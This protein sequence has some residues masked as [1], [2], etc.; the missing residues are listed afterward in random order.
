MEAHSA[1]HQH[2]SLDYDS[3]SPPQDHQGEVG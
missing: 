3:P 2:W 1:I